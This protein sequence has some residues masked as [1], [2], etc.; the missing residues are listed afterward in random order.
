MRKEATLT[1][2]CSL[3][4]ILTT[5]SSCNRFLDAKP[6]YR[7]STPETLDDL[8]ALLD[9]EAIINQNYPGMTETGTDDYYIDEPQLASAPPYLQQA[10][11]WGAEVTATDL[12]SWTKPYEAVMVSNVV[13]ENIERVP[14]NDMTS[15]RQIFGEASFV[16]GFYLFYLTQLYC[17][18]YS[19]DENGELPGLPLKYSADITEKIQRATL[20]ETYDRLIADLRNAAYYLPEKS[21]YKTRA[22]K[23]AAYAALSRVFLSM[24]DYPNAENMADS[25]LYFYNEILDYG[26]LDG[27]ATYPFKINNAEMIYLAKAT[28]GWQ[29][30]QTDGTF[31]DSLLYDSYAG[32]DLRKSIL[33]T[34]NAS[35]TVTFKGFYTGEP[36]AFFAGLSVGELYLTK[37]ECLARRN[38]ITGSLV[39][40]N[41]LLKNRWKKD[42]YMA[43][44][45]MERSE[46]LTK[47][48]EERRKELIY[49]G[50]RWMDI[51]RRNR[52]DGAGIILKRKIKKEG[53]SIRYE[54]L[55]NDAR[56]CYPIPEEIIAMSGLEQNRR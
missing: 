10:Y 48:F 12:S 41:R 27:S 56:Y 31:V 7:L 42:T 19:A 49:K 37:A 23:G 33:F 11:V 36:A 35:G 4:L 6:D 15:F 20:S 22:T 9:N 30:L 8:R 45:A 40:L 32:D 2:A 50:V 16:R 21:A 39:Y 52:F 13:L 55:P 26:T 44:S 34:K 14:H 53:N 28:T 29:L 46:L 47:I 54:L 43:I 24:A 1:I 18:P 38:N 5:F 51:R 17:L 3:L 25:A